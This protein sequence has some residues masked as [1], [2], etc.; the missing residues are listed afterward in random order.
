MSEIYKKVAIVIP[1]HKAKLNSDE[2]ISIKCLD[3]NL[4]NFDKYIVCPQKIDPIFDLKKLNTIKFDDKYFDNWL[5]YNSLLKSQIFWKKFT[6]YQFI[7]LYQ[8]DCLVFRSNIEEWIDMNFSFIGPP[9]IN[10]KKRK[11]G[12]VGNGGFSLRKVNDHLNAIE[13][14][15][16]N[17]FNF[18]KQAIKY[19][20]ARKRLF[21]LVKT[22]A[23]VCLKYFKFRI[24]KKKS[25]L[26]ETFITYSVYPEDVFWCMFGPILNNDFTICPPEKAID[27]GFES[28]PRIAYEI[29][30][31]K[32]P[33]GCHNWTRYDK[34][35][36]SGLLND[37]L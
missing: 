15:K 10:R 18:K 32:K 28:D 29:N 16:I 35:F 23:L 25:S 12:F 7:L 33:F 9:Q 11:L 8:L 19:F 3:R 1:T 21:Y 26:K 13:S 14:N 27:F 22:L 4:N 20:S 6:N 31:N 5:N 36:I 24:A 2:E 30:Q 17:F 37:K 34:V